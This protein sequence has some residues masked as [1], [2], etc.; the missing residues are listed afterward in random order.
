[1]P[2]HISFGR[3]AD[4]KIKIQSIVNQHKPN[5][6]KVQ[7]NLELPEDP[8]GSSDMKSADARYH[9]G[10]GSGRF[11]GGVGGE[12]DAMREPVAQGSAAREDGEKLHKGTVL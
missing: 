10:V 6:D 8:P 3:I 1:M 7:A 9:V 5:P 11:S 4:Q 12:T 2:Y